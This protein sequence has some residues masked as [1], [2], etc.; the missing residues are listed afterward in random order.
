[1]T[2]KILINILSM[3]SQDSAIKIDNTLE[4]IDGVIESSTSS[5]LQ[6]TEVTFDSKIVA[7]AKIINVIRRLG[8]DLEI[9]NGK[10]NTT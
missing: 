1:M 2:E 9:T 6:Q 3:V 4:K 7:L 8:Y 5:S 10:T